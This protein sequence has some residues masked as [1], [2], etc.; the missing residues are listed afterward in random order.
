MRGLYKSRRPEQA[1]RSS[2]NAYRVRFAA[3]TARTCSGL[4]LNPVL[5]ATELR[6]TAGANPFGHENVA[7]VV[8]AGIVRVDEFARAPT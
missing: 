1:E 5:H 8:E 7:V 4:R 2:G 3:G 6:H